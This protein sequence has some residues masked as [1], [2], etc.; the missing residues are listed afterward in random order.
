MANARGK[1]WI[2]RTVSI[3][4]ICKF[5]QARHDLHLRKA[6]QMR[7]VFGHSKTSEQIGEEV[8]QNKPRRLRNNAHLLRGLYHV[9]QWKLLP[10]HHIEGG[11]M[12]FPTMKHHVAVMLHIANAGHQQRQGIVA[13]MPFNI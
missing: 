8:V 5:G 4:V 13:C 1:L 2:K 9:A 12:V 6:L 10:L 11:Q 3:E 7:V